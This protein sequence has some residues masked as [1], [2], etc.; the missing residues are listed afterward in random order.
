[1]LNL[2]TGNVETATTAAEIGSVTTK[3]AQLAV[4]VKTARNTLSVIT[5]TVSTGEQEPTV[6]IFAVVILARLE[7]LH[8]EIHV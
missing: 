8:R 4:S 3:A 6:G 7:I 1:M 2:S 5:V